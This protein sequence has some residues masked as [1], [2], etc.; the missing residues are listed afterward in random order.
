MPRAGGIVIG[1]P[2]PAAAADSTSLLCP[3]K[4]LGSSG[5]SSARLLR[6]KKEE[7]NT[8]P[9]PSA[10]KTRISAEEQPERARRLGFV[11]NLEDKDDE[12]GPS[13]R[14]GDSGQGYSSWAAKAEPASEDDDGG[15][16]DYDVFYQRLGMQ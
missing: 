1:S 7:G 9:A 16:A 11:V 6:V 5:A 4:E 3:K 10:K 15:G 2:P 14:R 8:P 12:A 13:Q